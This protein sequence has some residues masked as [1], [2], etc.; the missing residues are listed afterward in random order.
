MNRT[1]IVRRLEQIQ[2]ARA[3]RD[4]SLALMAEALLLLLRET[5]KKP[6]GR[7]KKTAA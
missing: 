2:R 1:E 6:V 7:P 5:E 4:P 3:D